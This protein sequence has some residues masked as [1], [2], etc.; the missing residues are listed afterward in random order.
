MKIFNL[1]I[2][3]IGWWGKVII[4]RLSNSNQINISYLVDPNPDDEAIKLAQTKNLHIFNSYVY[5]H[6]CLFKKAVRI[7]KICL[8]FHLHDLFNL[9]QTILIF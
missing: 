8:P 9:S 4:N 6:V 7:Y 3:G 5:L 2:V 1:A